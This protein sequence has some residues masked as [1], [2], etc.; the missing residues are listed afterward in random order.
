MDGQQCIDKVKESPPYALILMD[1]QMPNV[2][3]YQATK[4]IRAW[5]KQQVM[6]SGTQRRETPIVAMT[7]Y[8]MPED[9]EK[10]LDEGMNDYISKPF[11]KEVLRDT[12]QRWINTEDTTEFVH[13]NEV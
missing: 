4:A 12:I 2:D 6:E 5:E 10:C 11:T 13:E 8:T 9:Q 7:A 3:G 1:C